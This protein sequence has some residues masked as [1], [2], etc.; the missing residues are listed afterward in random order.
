MGAWGIGSF[1]N[2]SAMDWVIDLEKSSDTALLREV[3]GPWER[4]S[5]YLNG[6]DGDMGLA[7]AEVVA[8]WLGRPAL[9]LPEEVALWVEGHK[10]LDLTPFIGQAILMIDRVLSDQSELNELWAENMEKY[11]SW[12]AGVL[13]LRKRLT[14]D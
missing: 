11:P 13:D 8:A 9:E 2:D 12:K 14:Q 3:L 6:G 10:D 1:D 5:D 7:A 4:D